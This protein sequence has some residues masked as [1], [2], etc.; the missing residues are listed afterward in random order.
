MAAGSYF[1]PAK[2]EFRRPKDSKK[3]IEYTNFLLAD[4]G[5]KV[6][7]KRRVNKPLVFD[8]LRHAKIT[9][10]YEKYDYMCNFQQ[11]R[12]LLEVFS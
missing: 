6:T 4:S 1:G 9:S 2:G 7:K 12:A 10:Y 3:K 5:V 11:I 8:W